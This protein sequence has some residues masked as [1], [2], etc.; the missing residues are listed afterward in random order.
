MA[1]AVDSL[2]GVTVKKLQ[3]LGAIL[4]A[5]PKA[6][7]HFKRP[8]L[9]VFALVTTAFVL[10]MLHLTSNHSNE[11]TMTAFAGTLTLL[12]GSGFLTNGA[13]SMKN[14]S[15]NLGILLGTLGLIMLGFGI[16]DIFDAEGSDRAKDIAAMIGGGILGF[17]M[18]EA[19]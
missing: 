8:R 19:D 15:S 4:M 1:V 7:S 16:V 2:K 3:V 14:H 9:A 12:V 11:A 5:I 13:R 6:L 10:V 18:D 17:F